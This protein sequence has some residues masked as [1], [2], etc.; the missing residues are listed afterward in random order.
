MFRSDQLRGQLLRFI[1]PFE[2]SLQRLSLVFATDQEHHAGCV[3]EDRRRH[4][5]R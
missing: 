4:G 2:D 1:V 5:H 3:I